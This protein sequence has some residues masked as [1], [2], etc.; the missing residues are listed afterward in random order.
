MKIPKIFLLIIILL[1][2]AINSINYS[3]NLEELCMNIN[4]F[5]D[6]HH[7]YK[8][9][10]LQQ[11]FSED[12]IIG[13]GHFG[14][15]IQGEIDGKNIVIKSIDTIS[16]GDVKVIV[17]EINVLRNIQNNPYFLNFHFCVYN[18]K[19]QKLYIFTELLYKDLKDDKFFLIKPQEEKINFYLQLARGIKELHSLGFVHNDIKP[20][21]IMIKNRNYEHPKLIDFG[22]ATKIGDKTIGGTTLCF[23][24]Q[25]VHDNIPLA[26]PEM[27]NVSFAVTIILLESRTREIKDIF[28]KIAPG[29]EDGKWETYHNQIAK[30][31]SG[32]YPLY[33][34][35]PNFLSK[36][37]RWVKSFFVNN[38]ME[39]IYNFEDFLN[40]LMENK[41]SN[42]L[43]MDEAI[44]LLE[45]FSEIYK[46]HEDIELLKKTNLI[47]VGIE[48][49]SEVLATKK[50]VTK[51]KSDEIDNE[52]KN[53][54]QDLNNE[55]NKKDLDN[56]DDL[57]T[58]EK[59]KD[60]LKTNDDDFKP[61][62]IVIV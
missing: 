36:A 51:K 58:K 42:R 4:D 45:R 3:D 27:D 22:L 19:A 46:N 15:V 24:Y 43:T 34:E 5:E 33:I 18:Q 16:A 56:E 49:N 61:K 20:A 59:S 32:K 62:N 48:E 17:A 28:K 54:E 35:N 29:T 8:N 53:K 1:L 60:E 38:N 44:K 2:S 25:K 13:K 52:K 40:G 37:W 6:Q 41:I 10:T 26:Q 30:Y 50:V 21:N 57:K 12:K 14:D 9:K 47:G 55:D 23:P 39:R 31:I 11:R 7:D